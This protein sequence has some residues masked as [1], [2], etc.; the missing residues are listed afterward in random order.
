MQRTP[1]HMHTH[2]INADIRLQNE[3][4]IDWHAVTTTHNLDSVLFS[5][6]PRMA[7]Y[8]PPAT[9]QEWIPREKLCNA[10]VT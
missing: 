2:R 6:N 9:V 1:T 3:T 10:A 8:V 5:H 4:E 7:T